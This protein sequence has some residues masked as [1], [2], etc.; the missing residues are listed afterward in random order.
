MGFFEG[1]A[2]ECTRSM[3]RLQPLPGRCIRLLLTPTEC[4]YSSATDSC[5]SLNT[6]FCL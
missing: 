1:V 2:G 3:L 5:W 4:L 6:R